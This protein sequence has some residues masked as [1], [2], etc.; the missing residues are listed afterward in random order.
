M[1]KH[2]HYECDQQTYQIIRN[3]IGGKEVYNKEFNQVITKLLNDKIAYKE[4]TPL[5]VF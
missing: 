1:K 4:R 2:F 3:L 5:G